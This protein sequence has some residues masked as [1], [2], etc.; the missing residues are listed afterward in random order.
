MLDIENTQTPG[1]LL[2]LFHTWAQRLEYVLYLVRYDNSVLPKVYNCLVATNVKPAVISKVLDIVEQLQS[3]A[4]ADEAIF[5]Q[6]FKPHVSCLLED[7]STLVTRS[8]GN[9]SAVTDVLGRRQITILSELAP[10]RK[11]TRLN[12]SHSGESR[13]P[14]SA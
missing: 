2:D 6:V 12:S 10:D 5:G 3:H 13:M 9:V 1:A 7:L 14:S 11:S 4:V 8:K